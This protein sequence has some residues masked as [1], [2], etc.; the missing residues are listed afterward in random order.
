MATCSRGSSGNTTHFQSAHLMRLRTRQNRLTIL[1][2]SSYLHLPCVLVCVMMSR[3]QR[4]VKHHSKAR[5][6]PGE[7]T[8][9]AEWQLHPTVN[10]HLHFNLPLDWH[11]GSQAA[12]VLTYQ[13]V[14]REPC[15]GPSLAKHRAHAVFTESS[16]NWVLM[17]VTAPQDTSR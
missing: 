11:A 3:S 8:R 1:K 15:S 4:G 6:D 14:K 17:S 9:R 16:T 2:C 13:D 7:G 10:T 5:W 12:T